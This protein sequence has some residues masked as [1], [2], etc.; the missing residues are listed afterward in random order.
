MLAT[1]LPGYRALVARLFFF[2]TA[3]AVVCDLLVRPF[4]RTIPGALSS[5]CT[6]QQALAFEGSAMRAN[7]RRSP[8]TRATRSL[9]TSLAHSTCAVS[10]AGQPERLILVTRS[11]RSANRTRG[12]QHG[13]IHTR[14]RMWTRPFQIR[15]TLAIYILAI[16]VAGLYPTWSVL[17]PDCDRAD[18]RV[19]SMRE[20]CHGPCTRCRANPARLPN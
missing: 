5:P 7:E 14:A 8:V 3:R 16:Y 4:R 20:T 13:E 2:N 19:R 15:T 17:A 10:R 18:A 11:A 1:S 12:A 9:V 6:L